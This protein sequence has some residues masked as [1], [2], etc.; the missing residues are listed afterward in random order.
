MTVLGAIFTGFTLVVIVYFVAFFI[1]D[2]A[3][4]I[5]GDNTKRSGQYSRFQERI[6]EAT[7]TFR[8]KK[9]SEKRSFSEVSAKFEQLELRVQALEAYVTSGKYDLDREFNKMR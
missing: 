1:L 5:F 2:P 3:P 8:Y 4:R 7:E 6:N 9:A